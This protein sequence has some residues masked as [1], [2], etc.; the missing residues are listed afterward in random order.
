MAVLQLEQLVLTRRYREQS[1]LPQ[2]VGFQS[3]N[4]LTVNA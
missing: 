4:M 1:L 2:L 3:G